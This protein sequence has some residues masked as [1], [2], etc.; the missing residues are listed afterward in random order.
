V[1]WVL[2]YED[3]DLWNHMSIVL[4][5]W[6]KPIGWFCNTIVNN[7]D[8]VTTYKKKYYRDFWSWNDKKAQAITHFSCLQEFIAKRN[9]RCTH[10][11]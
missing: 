4:Y 10:E 9:M 8:D 7:I 3:V 5:Q 2:F 11:D 1:Y 6:T